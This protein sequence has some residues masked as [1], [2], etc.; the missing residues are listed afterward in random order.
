MMR[1]R[2]P[3]D[4]EPDQ[5]SS[6]TLKPAFGG[7]SEEKKGGFLSPTDFKGTKVLLVDDNNFN[8]QVTGE[9]LKQ[10][11]LL[12]KEADNGKDAVAATANDSFDVVLMDIEMPEMDGYEAA[13]LIREEEAQSVVGN[14]PIIAMTAHATDDNQERC[15]A[16][17]MDGHIT[18]PINTEKLIYILSKWIEPNKCDYDPGD[19]LPS[20]LTAELDDK[21][22]PELSGIDTKA[23]LK[24]VGGNHELLRKLIAKFLKNYATTTREII[25]AV[26][27]GD[28]EL[29][30][31]LAHNIIGVAGNIGATELYSAV[32]ALD[33][34]VKQKKTGE[35]EAR[36]NNF[37]SAMDTVLNSIRNSI[38]ES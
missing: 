4:S 22:F 3:G 10:A 36:L 5:G 33:N 18:K 31:Q 27:G 7:K 9:F 8:R 1:V 37:I 12:V 20:S 14:V 26:R 38:K 23:G 32:R 30:H 15:L 16:A 25:D 35:M 28:F 6:F 24:V 29:A 34:A 13:R 11:G 21:F 19:M 2:K 17:G